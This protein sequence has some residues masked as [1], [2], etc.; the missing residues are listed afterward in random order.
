VSFLRRLGLSTRF[1][2][3]LVAMHLCFVGVAGWLLWDRRVWLLAV[4]TFAAVSLGVGF[5]LLRDLCRGLQP[6]DEAS[7]L[8]AERD[9]TTRFREVGQPEVD[10]LVGVYNRMADALREERTR[11]EEQQGL[12]ARILDVSPS[13]VVI[14]DYEGRVAYANPAAEA[15][16]GS[17]RGGLVGRVPGAGEGSLRAALGTLEPGSALIV[18]LQGARRIRIHRGTFLDRG[19][20]RSFLLLEELTEELRESERAAYGKVVRLMSHEVGNT[21]GAGRSLLE[22]SLAYAARLPPADAAT[23]REALGVVIARLGQLQDFTEGFAD[24]VRLPRPR[25]GPCDL[26]VVAQSVATLL[27]PAGETRGTG[28]EVEADPA[29]PM[30][31]ADRTQIEQ[32]LVNVVKNALEAAGA[33]GRVGV[34][35][36]LQGGRAALEVED[37]G[38]G[39]LPEVAERLFTPFFST[40]EEGRGLGL[41][42]VREVLRQHGCDFGLEGPP[43]G[44]TRFWILFP[45]T[46]KG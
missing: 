6:L 39:L 17:S 32:A 33:G 13:G 37:S 34:R 1:L 27:A 30:V 19:F 7:R 8:L 41:T 10:R 9:F 20:Q 42:L 2:V 29:A 31:S 12:L 26:A 35:V 43:G 16:L 38:P 14:L 24:V 23:F 11:N 3:Y 45:E 36:G 18:P 46:T 40:R 5:L 44:P 21:V 22:S 4:E 28:L 25:L 15:L